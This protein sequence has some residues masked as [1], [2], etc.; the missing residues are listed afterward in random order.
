MKK[1]FL[2]LAAASALLGFAACN[3]VENGLVSEQTAG[4]NIR[5]V[6]P[7]ALGTKAPGDTGADLTVRGNEATLNNVTVFLFDAGGNLI[8]DGKQAAT[9]A[10]GEATASWAKVRVGTYTCAAVANFGS[11]TNDPFANVSTLTALETLA[12]GLGDNDPAS[13]FVMAGKGTVTVNPTEGTNNANAGEVKISR[14][15]SR[16]R[17]VSVEN[18]LNAAY[19]DFTVDQVFV[20]N[21]NSAWNIGGNGEP[22][23]YFNWAGRTA[24]NS[25]K[26][27]AWGDA[28]NYIIKGAADA[29]F[30]NMTFAAPAKAVAP[31]VVEPFDLPF[32]TLQNAGTEDHFD[33]P[34]DG[35]VLTRL[36]VRASFGGNTYFYPVTI[37]KVERNKTYDVIISISGPG[38]DDPNKGVSTGALNVTISLAEWGDGGVTTVNF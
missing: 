18:K 26:A 4:L 32:Y 15:V 2:T 9:I 34:T 19:T 38:S 31:G 14:L 37:N 11:A 1:L 25:N 35:A 29:Q 5:I 13:G 22:T 12:A 10:A 16:I 23:A 20:I 30:A 8:V 24:G 6:T 33:G 3:E 7:D 21:G 27:G 28:G 36:V 17:L